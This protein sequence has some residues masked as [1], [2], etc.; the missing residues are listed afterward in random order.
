VKRGGGKGGGDEG[1]RKWKEGGERMNR[2]VGSAGADK[3]VEG[4]EKRDMSEK[5]SGVGGGVGER[6]KGRGGGEGGERGERE[7]EGVR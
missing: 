5:G 6:V 4:R 2:R 7:Q 1:R 3:K